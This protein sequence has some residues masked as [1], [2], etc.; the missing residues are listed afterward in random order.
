M[1]PVY[2][3]ISTA[4]FARRSWRTL[5]GGCV[6]NSVETLLPGRIAGAKKKALNACCSRRSCVG[7]WAVSDEI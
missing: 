3:P 1:A 7:I 6:A 4:S 2:W 5:T